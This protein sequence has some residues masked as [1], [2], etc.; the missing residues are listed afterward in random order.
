[1]LNLGVK[2]LSTLYVVQKTS[3]TFL[4]I[5]ADLKREPEMLIPQALMYSLELLWARSRFQ[6]DIAYV[7]NFLTHM[8]THTPFSRLS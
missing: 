1:M 2:S 5:L 6:T 8:F 3:Y 4:N 7:K